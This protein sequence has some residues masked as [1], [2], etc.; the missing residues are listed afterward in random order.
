MPQDGQHFSYRRGGGIVVKAMSYGPYRSTPGKFGEERANVKNPHRV[1]C[2][3]FVPGDD[4]AI[5]TGSICHPLGSRIV[6]AA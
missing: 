2:R 4:P 6:C 3:L 1:M 5:P